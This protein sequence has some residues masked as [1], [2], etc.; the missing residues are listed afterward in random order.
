[1]RL[2]SN[3]SHLSSYQRR[4]RDLHHQPPSLNL[5][6]LRRPYSATTPYSMKEDDQIISPV[7]GEDEDSEVKHPCMA[8]FVSPSHPSSLIPLQMENAG[9]FKRVPKPVMVSGSKAPWSLR[10]VLKVF[11]TK[12]DPNYAQPWQMTPQRNTTGSAFIISHSERLILTNSHVVS[13]SVS[14]FV[15]R[16]VSHSTFLTV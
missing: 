8:P 4:S 15:R 5:L 11:S 12:V 7:V 3:R 13:G 14:V 1:M 16:P 2:H 9:S 6:R 10:S